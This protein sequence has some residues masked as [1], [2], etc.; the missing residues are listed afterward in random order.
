MALLNVIGAI[1]QALDQEMARDKSVVVF[2][3]DVGVE[4]GVFR[5]TVD[6]QKKHGK[7]RC[8]D[9]PLAEAAIIGTAVGMAINGLKP[10]AEIQFSGF[11]FPGYDQIVSHVARMRNRTRGRFNL[12][13][14]IRM[15][16]GG[17]IRALEHHSE[18]LE[19]LFGHI[20]GLKVVVP[21]TPYDAKGLLL[22]AIR[23]EDPVLFLEPTKIYR[24][25][26]Q[27]VPE[28]DYVIPIGKAKVVK[29]GNDITVVAWG[30][31]LR[32]TEKAVKQLEEEG[33]SVELIDLRTI[34]PIDKDTIIESVKKT[35]RFVVVH[36]ACKTYGPGAELISIVNEGA[37]LNLETPP[38][39]L[40][41]FDI[42][43]PLPRGEH[44]YLL[45][46]K[47]IADGIRKVA[48]F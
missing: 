17:G 10:I 44:H 20:P 25:F 3:E 9:T 47:R 43:V 41:G 15:P 40:A 36:E 37:F 42:T 24:A 13:M 35:G 8:F 39:R 16:H 23:D 30:A 2:G 26:K 34:S 29:P 32:E 22:A 48:R 1:N 12:P 33:I 38:T 45:D 46:S 31:Y 21:S 14:V 4:G 18:N 28:E 19:T 27:E 11:V 5:A 6:L 7:D